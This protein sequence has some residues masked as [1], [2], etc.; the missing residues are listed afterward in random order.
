MSLREVHGR[1]Q[2][3]ASAKVILVLDGSESATSCQ[4]AISRLVLAVL[5]DLP[6]RVERAL[7]FLGNA[8]S[9]D[10]GRVTTDLS[11]W[12]RENQGRLSLIAPVFEHLNELEDLR[13]IIIGA[14][15]IFDLEDW[16]GTRLLERTVLITM[17]ESLQERKVAEELVRPEPAELRRRLDDPVARVQISGRGFMPTAWDNSGYHMAR[18]EEGVALVGPCLPDYSLTV[19]FLADSAERSVITIVRASGDQSVVP[20]QSEAAQRPAEHTVRWL[21]PQ[22]VQAFEQ[23]VRQQAFKCPYPDCGKFCR[24]NAL[25]CYQQGGFGHLVYPSLEKH[26]VKG[27][28][29]FRRESK[30]ISFRPVGR[31]VLRLTADKVVLKWEGSKPRIHRYDAEAGQWRET[32]E[33]FE[34]YH[35]MGANV[36]AVFV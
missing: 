12:F 16:K 6:A 15:R 11:Q 32:E 26:Q 8:T 24:W 27:F 25:R 34:C 10:S 19:I 23:A 31:S 22:E 21:G 35:R 14:G 20:I 1:I 2:M 33:T 17:G 7:Y 9:Y 29:L 3:M 28:V 13:I 5:R 18:L 4:A 30:G 36:Y